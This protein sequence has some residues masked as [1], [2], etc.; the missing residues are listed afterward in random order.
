MKIRRYIFLFLII[1]AVSCACRD[2][3]YAQYNF[4]AGQEWADINNDNMPDG[5][6]IFVKKL[7]LKTAQD[8]SIFSGTPIIAETQRDFG[9]YV[10][11]VDSLYAQED[12]SRLPIYFVFKIADMTKSNFDQRQIAMYKL[13]IMQ[14]LDRIGSVE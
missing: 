11:I 5:Q 10:D 12:N 4:F 6:K 13:A 8:A 2:L 3:S 14:Q 1:C 9:P 7:L